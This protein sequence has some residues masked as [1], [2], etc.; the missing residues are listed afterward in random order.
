[1]KLKKF[2][3]AQ[4]KA[5][6]RV[7]ELCQTSSL[8]GIAAVWTL[9]V[10]NSTSAMPRLLL[11][12]MVLF[13]AAL[14]GDFIQHVWR[15]AAWGTMAR[16]REKPLLS[17]DGEQEVLDPPTWVNRITLVFFV[18]KILVMLTGFVL[19]FVEAYALLWQ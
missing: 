17:K 19:L 12:A 7:S 5:S 13:A 10:G 18:A 16:C 8:G 15:T 6:T 2:R 11:W 1:M 4:S 9:R 14:L 3:D